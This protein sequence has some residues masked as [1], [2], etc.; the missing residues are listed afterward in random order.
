METKTVDSEL[1]ISVGKLARKMFE[2][3]WQRNKQVK[4]I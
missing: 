2:P 1:K 4:Q 3:K